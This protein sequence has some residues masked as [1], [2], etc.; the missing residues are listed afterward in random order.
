MF[1]ELL[2]RYYRPTYRRLLSKVIA[3]SLLHVDE[4]EVKLQTGKGYVWVFTTL[5][6]VVFLYRPTR[7]GD[8]LREL[9]KDFR[10]VLVSDYYAAYDSLD[11]A[12]QK[13]LIHLMR[14]MNQEILNNPYDKELQSIT[15]AFGILLRAVVAT[16][17][18]HGL[19]RRYLQ[20]HEREVAKFFRDLADHPF[21]SEAADALQSRLLK[22]RGKLFTFLQHDGVPWNNNN[23]E[24]SIKHFAYYRE[25]TVGSLRECGLSDYLVLL[26]I[27]QTCRYNRVSFLKFLLSRQKDLRAFCEGTGSKRRPS[28][29]E[30]Y[31]RGF[32][33]SHFRSKL[34]LKKGHVTPTKIP[35]PKPL[36][37]AETMAQ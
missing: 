12:Q 11:C 10:G 20:R 30:L 5:E 36:G 16:I 31:P 9:L 28:V 1:K 4:T 24:N 19:K 26:S 18:Q 37:A 6:E 15:R 34:G 8:F 13:C 22:Y 27:C 14:D 32:V 29:I 23:A 35:S 21:N 2:V 33:P 7:E 3:G 17:D 25:N